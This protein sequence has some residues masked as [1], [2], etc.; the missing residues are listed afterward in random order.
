MELIDGDL[1]GEAD[2]DLASHPIV[3]EKYTPGYFAD[4]FDK[5]AQINVLEI[6]RHQV[7]VRC[8]TLTGDTKA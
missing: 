7:R 5:D 1:I 3:Q 4:K 2:A 8:G 6:D